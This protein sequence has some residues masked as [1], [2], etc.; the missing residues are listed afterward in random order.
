MKKK[1]KKEKKINKKKQEADYAVVVEPEAVAVKIE[2]EANIKGFFNDSEEEKEAIPTE[3]V[4]TKWVSIKEGDK[5]IGVC[6]LSEP[7][8]S[9]NLTPLTV[10]AFVQNNGSSIHYRT[11][12]MGYNHKVLFNENS[13]IDFDWNDK[14]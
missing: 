11:V 3:I 12:R 7:S 1:I 13:N 6:L 14:L 8:F 10:C 5:I 2:E 9:S 4:L